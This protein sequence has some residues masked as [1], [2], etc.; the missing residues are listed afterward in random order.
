[1]D[2]AGG[3]GGECRRGNQQ[4]AASMPTLDGGIAGAEA[5]DRRDARDDQTI[6][7]LHSPEC[8]VS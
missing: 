3:S 7:S 1:V 8:S 6:L 4:R 2:R 5:I